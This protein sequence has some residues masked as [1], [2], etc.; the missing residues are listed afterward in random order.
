MEI[1]AEVPYGRGLGIF[2]WEPDWIAVEGAGWYTRG[3]DGWDNQTFFDHDGKALASLNVFRAVSQ[4]RPW[5]DATP[6]SVPPQPPIIT[7]KGTPVP[8]PDSANVFYSDDSLRQV[9][10]IWDPLD[11]STWNTPG[12]IDLPGTM[13]AATTLGVTL[14]ITVTLMA[15]PGFEQGTNTTA[16]GW[17]ITSTPAA[18]EFGSFA[19]DFRSG[20]RAFHWW[21]AGAFTLTIEQT[22]TGLDTGKTYQF[23]FWAMG[24]WQE[25]M[26]AYA[27]CPPDEATPTTLDFTLNGWASDPA[28]WLNP[29]IT[30]LSS[31]TG[32]CRVGVTS[33]ARADDWGSLDDFSMTEEP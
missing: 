3:G 13:P 31:S 16:P 24:E 27:Y 33:A 23:G 29:T 26:Q 22:V 25:P 14:P 15:N 4:E 10:V 32:A 2:Y 9:Y 12:T 18:S 5:V 30:G 6:A 20:G 11:A 19:R 28:Q 8:L 7:A 1:V 17:T 21:N